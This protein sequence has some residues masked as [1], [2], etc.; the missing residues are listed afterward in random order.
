LA[1]VKADARPRRK[2]AKTKETGKGSYEE[3]L[4]RE[5]LSVCVATM[6]RYGV[7][8]KKV[9]RALLTSGD[10]TAQTFLAKVL[11]H[12][13]DRLGDLTNE[14]NENPRFLDQSGRPMVLP[15]RGSGATFETLVRKYF[16]PK[17]LTEILE[18]AL[19]TR[20]VERI[21]PDQVAPVNKCVM[22]TGDR[23][24]LLAR[25]VLSVQWLLSSAENNGISQNEPSKSLP[26][27]MACGYIPKEC[28]AEFSS[29]MRPHLYNVLDMGNRW[30]SEHT[31]RD[32]PEGA[33]DR[34]A[35]VGL[36]AYVFRE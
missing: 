27:R 12:N 7:D 29:L 11:F 30:L 5:L 23:V 6:H 2:I 9:L 17:R 4:A 19:H 26:E 20:V 32:A 33:E 8:P 14:W 25:A 35:L 1:A 10:W 13:A 36:H 21:G 3:L 16:G 34:A 31:V 24:L 15:L 28:V 18:F 22:L